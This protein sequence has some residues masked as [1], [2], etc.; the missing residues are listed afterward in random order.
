MIRTAQGTAGRVDPPAA[1][2]LLVLSHG[3]ASS[4]EPGTSSAGSAMP[5]RLSM[6]APKIAFVGAGSTVFAR[7]LLR[8]LFMFPELH[9]ATISLMDID[10]DR[11]ATTEIVAKR[12]I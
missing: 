12:V 2:R 8:D 4:G 9:H 6:T 11:L 1:C 5:G 10:P 7:A 3:R